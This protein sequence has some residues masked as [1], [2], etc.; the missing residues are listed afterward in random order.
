MARVRTLALLLVTLAVAATAG[1]GLARGGALWP[2]RLA[3]LFL[4]PMAAGAIATLLLPRSAKRLGSS[5]KVLGTGRFHA[6][7]AGVILL[8][9]AAI[10]VGYLLGWATLTYGEQALHARKLL[11]V[12]LALPFTIAVATLGSEWALHARLWEVA[13]RR[14]DATTASILAVGVGTALALPVILPGFDVVD[15]GFVASAIAVALLREIVALRLFR[16]GGLFVAGAYR[17]TLLALEGF[18][19]ADWH[20]F[21]F[22]LA[23]YVSSTPAFPLLRVVGPAVGVAL[24]FAL[25]RRRAPES[26]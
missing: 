21:L 8:D 3:L 6:L 24:L 4:L 12:P 14:S 16:T 20:S 22:P 17:G 7:V 5:A 15:R 23:N 26:T 18:G 19:L 25:T 11:A 10:G 13:A 9:L 2:A 1:A